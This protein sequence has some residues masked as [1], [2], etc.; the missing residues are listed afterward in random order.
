MQNITVIASHLAL[1]WVLSCQAGSSCLVL[2]AGDCGDCCTCGENVGGRW[3]VV[4]LRKQQ[5]STY[6]PCGAQRLRS[7]LFLLDIFH[8]V[9]CLH[10]VYQKMC[11]PLSFSFTLSFSFCVDKHKQTE[12]ATPTHGEIFEMLFFA[13]SCLC[14]CVGNLVLETQHT[15]T[16]ASLRFSFPFSLLARAI[17]PTITKENQV[18]EDEEEAVAQSQI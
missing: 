11:V 18:G 13:L 17:K 6:T 2:V 14:V 8:F 4:E 7:V 16:F 12:A 1:V 5:L 3:G 10:Y 9:A 15:F